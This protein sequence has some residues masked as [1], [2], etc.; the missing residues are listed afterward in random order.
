MVEAGGWATCL[1]LADA[2]RKDVPEVKYVAQADFGG[3]HSLMA[4]DKKLYSKGMFAG[5][6][7]LKIFRFPLLEGSAEEVLKQPASIVLTQSAAVDL[8][9]HDVPINRMVRLDNLHDVK[10]AG[11][12]ADLPANS[13]MTFRGLHY[14]VHFFYVQT[15]DWIKRRIWAIGTWI[16]SQTFVALQPNVSKE[17]AEATFKPI[18]KNM[19][20]EM[21]TRLRSWKAFHLPPAG[22][23][24][25]Q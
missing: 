23:A 9:R 20:M 13:S 16:R 21:A 24:F 11:V 17:Q 22:L 1:P 18:Y 4:G 12:L 25:V 2:I 3:L 15:Q 6:D 7:F 19:I 5:E 8:F 10:V 14:P